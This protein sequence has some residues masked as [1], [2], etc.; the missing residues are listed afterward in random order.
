M[1]VLI[2]VVEMFWQIVSMAKHFLIGRKCGHY[3]S[4]FFKLQLQWGLPWFHG[5][6]ETW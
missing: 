4:A 5:D 1:L 6:L 3:Y 2:V